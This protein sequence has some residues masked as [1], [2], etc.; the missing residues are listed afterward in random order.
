MTESHYSYTTMNRWFMLVIY[1]CLVAG[2]VFLVITLVTGADGPPLPFAVLW[3][4]ILIWNG[5]WL[6]WRVSNRLEVE[7]ELLRWQTPLRRG[8]VPVG[9][10]ESIDSGWFGRMAVVHVRDHET[11][12]CLARPGILEFAN[13]VAVKRGV[14]I[15]VTLPWLE[16]LNGIVGGTTAFRRED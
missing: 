2:G 6:L 1:A 13:E 5:Y 14:P 7:G 15:N 4:G 11:I 8:Q 10:V 9:D 12:M 3:I 16:R